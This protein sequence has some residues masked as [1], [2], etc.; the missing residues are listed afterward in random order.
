L[1]VRIGIH[2]GEPVA[3]HNDLFGA[4]VLMAF[5]CAAKPRPVASWSP[6]SCANC[7][8]KTPRALS[9]SASED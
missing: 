3:E 7:P 1:Q 8:A 9:R 4:T 2:A 5:A 6:D